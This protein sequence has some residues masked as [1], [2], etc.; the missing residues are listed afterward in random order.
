MK[1]KWIGWPLAVVVIALLALPK[2][3]PDKRATGASGRKSQGPPPPVR[4]GIHVVKKAPLAST[5]Q[6]VGSVMAREEIDLRSETQGRIV[7]IGFEEGQ[8]VRK[9][10]LLLK[11]NDSDL[12]AQ[13]RKTLAAKKLKEDTEK[14]NRQLL[15]KG[16]ISQEAYEMAA[17]ELRTAEAD[18]ELIRE[19][20]RKTEVI[21]PFDGNIGLKYVSEGSFITNA[22]PIA[23]L[24]DLSTVKID[25]SLPG[26]YVS[27]VNE[28]LKIKFTVEGDPKEH[29]A[30]VYA[31][32]PR[33]DP[34]TR[35]IQIR[36]K[37]ENPGQS[38]VPG[39]FARIHITLS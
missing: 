25:F 27:Q 11:I 22:T 28:G 36:A 19:Q 26:K 21:A 34:V 23:R 24:Q 9:G 39:A 10:Q 2:L 38:L 4:V 6:A 12:Q 5:L 18:I 30:V 7:K 1:K 31:I 3:M 8:H 14:R 16:G 15:T 29:E 33:V 37:S 13:L 35:N 20:I 17:T 32:E